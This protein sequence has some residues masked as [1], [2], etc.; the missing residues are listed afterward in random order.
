MT[1]KK[2]KYN[3][4]VHS[5]MADCMRHPGTGAIGSFW[6]SRNCECV[7]KAIEEIHSE[8]LDEN[9]LEHLYCIPAQ[10]HISQSSNTTFI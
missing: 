3:A 9:Y 5:P 10:F 6:R 4:L 2:E 8:Q 1:L 7:C